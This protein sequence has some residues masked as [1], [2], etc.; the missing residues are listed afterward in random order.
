M[1]C[2]LPAAAK[3]SFPTGETDSYRGFWRRREEEAA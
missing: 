3:R 2:W 1:L